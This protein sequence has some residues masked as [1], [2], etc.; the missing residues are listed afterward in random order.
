[1]LKIGL[2]GGI[3]S[4]KSTVAKIFKTL[5]VPVYYADDAGKRLM[6]E[7]EALQ[8]LIQTNFGK[9]TYPDGKLNRKHLASVVFNDPQ[10][11]TLLNSFVHP[12]TI[13]DC[14]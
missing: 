6:N 5:G 3:G 2:T 14:L 7:D 4:G 9:E 10:K 8:Q 13:A 11:L 1:M 12:A